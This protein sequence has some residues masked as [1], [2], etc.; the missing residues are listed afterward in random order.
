MQRSR[1][2]GRFIRSGLVD[3]A[4]RKN[5]FLPPV[6]ALHFYLCKIRKRVDGTLEYIQLAALLSGDGEAEPLVAASHITLKAAAGERAA[7][8]SVPWCFVVIADKD[9]V[10]IV[11][12]FIQKSML[13][14]V[15]EYRY[16]NAA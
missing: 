9:S 8:C 12:G 2:L 1:H 6:R 14:A 13:K 7:Q 10:V 3:A 5:S 11:C 16:V 4:E 15:V